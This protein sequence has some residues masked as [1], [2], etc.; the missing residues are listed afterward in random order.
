MIKT[1]QINAYR[2]PFAYVAFGG[3]PTHWWTRFL[4]KGFYHCVLLI[5]N[6]FEW[7]L[8]DPVM[9]YTDLILMHQRYA[10]EIL[11]HKGYR[12]IRTTLTLP[13]TVSFH[14]RPMTCVETVK[15]FL[16]ISN[17]KIWTPYQLF[18]YLKSQKRK[19]FLDK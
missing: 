5:G 1:P 4:K 6:G 18:L 12:L 17:P 19:I 9:H 15:R 7:I 10:P 8:I 2:F 14:L 3:N 11:K 13:Q 16:G